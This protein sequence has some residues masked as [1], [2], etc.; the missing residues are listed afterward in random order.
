MAPVWPS[1]FSLC[2]LVVV[3]PFF[4]R[5]WRIRKAST[6]GGGSGSGQVRLSWEF[7]GLPSVGDLWSFCVGFFFVVCGPIV[8][9]VFVGAS[10]SFF[11]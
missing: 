9:A 3:S 5:A 11:R 2:L 4:F 10:C 7:R 1:E 6:L 8:P